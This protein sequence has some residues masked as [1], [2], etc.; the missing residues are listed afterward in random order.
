MSGSSDQQG[1]IS[2]QTAWLWRAS[3]NLSPLSLAEAL[4]MHSREGLLLGGAQTE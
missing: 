4:G 3:S 1:K 2:H